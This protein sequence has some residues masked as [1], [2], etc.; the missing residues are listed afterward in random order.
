MFVDPFE[1]MR[2]TNNSKQIL[3]VILIVEQSLQ[4]KLLED[5]FK[6]QESSYKAWCYQLPIQWVFLVEFIL[7]LEAIELLKQQATE[8][9]PGAAKTIHSPVNDQMLSAYVTLLKPQYY[10]CILIR[11]ARTN[12]SSIAIEEIKDF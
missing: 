7:P 2:K 9:S 8:T 1:S 11:R 12:C 4:S 5:A 3:M 10:S 6:F